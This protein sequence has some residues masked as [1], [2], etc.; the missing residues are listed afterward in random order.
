VADPEFEKL[1]QHFAEQQQ[2]AGTDD[3]VDWEEM[4]NWW[5]KAVHDLFNQIDGWLHS[6]ILSGSVKSARATMELTE[7]DLGRYKIESLE[8]QLASRKLIFKPEGTMLI[9]A[10]GR[11][12][13][14]GP[15]G[16]A[17]LLLLNTDSKVPPTERRAHVAW[18]IT[19]PAPSFRPPPRSRPELRP[20]T[21]DSFQQLFTD[22]FGISR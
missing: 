10:F 2:K 5:I 21:Q 13:V 11:V 22:L 18:F 8:L 3:V 7:E 19:R 20:L 9:G 16:K 14:T 15:N 17:V 4:K 12:E 6:L 1:V